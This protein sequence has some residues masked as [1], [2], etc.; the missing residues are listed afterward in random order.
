MS[1]DIPLDDEVAD[2]EIPVVSEDGETYEV[3]DEGEE[4]I[5][6]AEKAEK[7]IAYKEAETQNVRKRMLTEKSDAIKYGGMGMAR[8]MLTILADVDRALSALSDDDET[9][10]AQGLRL[11]RNKMWRE[12]EADGVKAIEVKGK[13]FDPSKME[14]ITTIPSSEHFAAGQV[15]DVLESG[16]MYKD[17]IITIARVVVASE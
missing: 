7:E 17:R 3:T 11:L 13:A 4:A 14:A 1:D 9:A 2:D 10:V 8:R 12:L 15:V 6:R 5:Q 16:F